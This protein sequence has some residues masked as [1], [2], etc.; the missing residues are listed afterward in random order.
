MKVFK[1][2]L[3]SS[4]DEEL[5]RLVKQK[6]TAAFEEIYKRY[7]KIYKRYSKTVLRY[8]S[9]MLG[10]SVEQAQDFLHDI[11]LKII[12]KPYLFDQTKKFKTW[13]FQIA[14]NKCKNEYRRRDIRNKAKTKIE[15]NEVYSQNVINQDTYIDFKQMSEIIN[16][17]LSKY[18]EEHFSTFLMRHQF[19][20]SIKEIAQVFDCPEGTVKS[21]LFYI[22]HKLVKKMKEYNQN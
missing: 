5:M 14:H 11:F 16:Y 1:P 17:E 8:L 18:K 3:S 15:L 9:K 10:G 22:T 4:S 2:S 6:N 19:E 20:M 12:E 7:S 13:I 21:R